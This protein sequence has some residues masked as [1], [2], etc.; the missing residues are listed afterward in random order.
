MNLSLGGY[1]QLGLI[2]PGA[3]LMHRLPATVCRGSAP[4]PRHLG[5]RQSSWQL[6]LNSD[7]R[8]FRSFPCSSHAD[9]PGHYKEMFSPALDA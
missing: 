6:L 8:V 5:T 1:S 4:S 7:V 3:G 9:S 2:L